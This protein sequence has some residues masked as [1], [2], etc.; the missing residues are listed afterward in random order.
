MRVRYRSPDD[1]LWNLGETLNR[2]WVIAP[3]RLPVEIGNPV[4]VEFK[5]PGLLAPLRTSGVLLEVSGGDGIEQPRSRVGFTALTEAAKGEID[6][7]LR[8]YRRSW[9]PARGWSAALDRPP[10]RATRH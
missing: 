3:G 4:L 2:G 10:G 9:S 7:L 5:I 8:R 6:R 1:L